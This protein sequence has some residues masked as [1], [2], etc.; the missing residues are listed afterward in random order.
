MSFILKRKLTPGI[1]WVSVND[2]DLHICCGSPADTAKHLRKAGLIK[3]LHIDGYH[4][5]SGPNAVLLSEKNIQKGYVSNLTEFP[6]M[7][8]LYMQGL[9]IPSHPNYKKI[10]P[11]L[12]G[13][14]DIIQSQTEY[15]YRGNYG[16][17]SLEEIL[18]TGVGKELA[19]KI[20]A[21]KK[22]FSFNKIFSP[23]DLFIKCEV[24][25]TPV[26]IKNKVFIQHLS[27]NRYKIL[28]K[29]EETV[30][31]LNLYDDESID[32]TY[33]LNNFEVERNYFSVI[34]NGEG[35]GWDITRPCMSSIISVKG[36]LYLVDAGPNISNS[37]KHLGIHPSEIKGVFISHIHDDHFAGITELICNENKVTIIAATPIILSAKKKL[38]AL[39]GISE[40]ALEYFFSF[41]NMEINKWNDLEDF[42]AK[43]VFSPHPVET[44][45]FQFEMVYNQKSY[46]FSHLADTIG[47]H[48]Y[49]KIVESYPEL[50]DK[51]L[52]E[53]KHAYLQKATVKKADVNGG[54]IHGRIEDFRHDKSDFLLYAHT[55]EPVGNEALNGVNANFG[56]CHSLIPESINLTKRAC[57]LFKKYFDISP[58]TTLHFEDKE[59]KRFLPGEIILPEERAGNVFY[60][61]LSG[62]VQ[63]E[64]GD[65]RYLYHDKLPG[66]IE[67]VTG[68]SDCR[69]IA[70]SHV[71]CM[72]FSLEEMA[73]YV[74]IRNIRYSFRNNMS[75][76]KLM[77]GT[78]FAG[79]VPLTEILKIGR[80]ATFRTYDAKKII[81]A[82]EINDLFIVVKGRAFVNFEKTGLCT[83]AP[84][85][86]IW[87]DQEFC[88]NTP[89]LIITFEENTEVL[90]V[91]GE[92][93]R[94]LPGTI[95]KLI[96]QH[97]DLMCLVE[98]KKQEV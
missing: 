18:S 36:N 27:T 28:Y 72:E 10:I 93:I 31:D 33:I 87:F 57:M 34:H 17:V 56:D 8:M 77:E 9:I 48:E 4:Y 16:L 58:E 59:I 14:K 63:Q 82:G 50:G 30:V 45:I 97:L 12:I 42:N 75:C 79:N 29:G 84:G 92:I 91:G 53:L 5:E 81:E 60:L 19:E 78:L 11:V 43:P 64:K 71:N 52:D 21:V 24:K 6:I 70:G 54:M 44:T 47:F 41:E 85:E 66:F 98:L 46:T 2:A 61:I 89:D 65:G 74:D 83:Y 76:V 15:L 39:T 94:K 95:W 35:N 26:E 13:R 32:T 62:I 38:S 3:N 20:Y 80:K 51:D 22:Y 40:K 90:V 68:S 73:K 69:Y 49:G 37:L 7:H 86:Y 96:E 1:I 55:D 88:N 25:E 67:Y 23:G